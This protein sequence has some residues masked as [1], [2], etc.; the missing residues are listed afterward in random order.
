MGR[1]YGS[2]GGRRGG[3]AAWQWV[4]IGL[5]LGFG[6]AIIAVL[7]LLVF[8][9]FQLGESDDDPQVASA[10]TQAAV[11]TDN[12]QATINAIRAEALSEAEA[13]ATIESRVS[14]A[15]QATQD[16]QP[17]VESQVMP[18]TATPLPPTPNPNQATPTTGSATTAQ[19]Q[20]ATP[21]TTSLGGSTAQTSNTE[22]GGQTGPTE[23]EDP[24]MQR[25][26]NLASS[27][28][29][30]EGGT[31]EMGTNIEEIRQAVNECVNRDQGTCEIRYGQDSVPPHQVT[32]DQY[33]IEQTEV[34]N[35]QYVAF[36]NAMGPG[37]HRDGCSGQLCVETTAENE[38]SL[39]TFD[40]QNYDVAEQQSSF[41]VVGVTWYGAQAYCESIGRRL[42]TEAEWEH[43][44]RGDDNS[45]YPWG[46]QWRM[47]YA[48][49][50]RPE[51]VQTPLQVGSIPENASDYGAVDM[52]GNVAEWVS[53][54]Y[55]VDHYAQQAERAPVENPTG[56]ASGT[57]R[58]IR[59]GSWNSVP[60]FSRSVHR[61]HTRPDEAFLWLGF[62]C[63]SDTGP[64]GGSG[65][66]GAQNTGGSGSG[67]TT[68]LNPDS[69]GPTQ[70]AGGS[71]AATE[72]DIDARPELPGVPTERANVTATPVPEVPPGGNE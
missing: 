59:G 5:T 23:A 38:F 44:A 36:L 14:A 56:P 31:F 65:Q 62:R 39:I 52:A 60:F 13:E 25:L 20:A 34:T 46:N 64:E 71:E 28:V 19:Q 41:P 35:Q 18:P 26:Q 10:L 69:I 63:V 70:S 8:G 30:V 12:V 68:E 57:D 43:A 21:T 40:S 2:V 24:R 3:S 50:S 42:P 55:F 51:R 29:P 37:S 32:L 16:A 72:E 53:D 54:W 45:I 7:M 67:G 58:V 6:L 66:S 17:T 47:E 15:I 9:V 27:L 33:W 1:T 48:R 22:T 49:T 11:P 4:I 61:R